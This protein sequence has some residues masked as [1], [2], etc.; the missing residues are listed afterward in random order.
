MFGGFTSLDFG[1]FVFDP[2]LTKTGKSAPPPLPAAYAEIVKKHVRP[3]D[4]QAVAHDVLRHRLI[5]TFEAEADGVTK[6]SL[7]DELIALVPVS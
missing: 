3:L 6:D 5:L 2:A 7:I 4:V 1:N